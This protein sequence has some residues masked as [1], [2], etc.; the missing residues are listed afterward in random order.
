M[1]QPLVLLLSLGHLVV[2][3]AVQVVHDDEAGEDRHDGDV[4]DGRAVQAVAEAAGGLQLGLHPAAALHGGELPRLGTFVGKDEAI[5]VGGMLQLG[6]KLGE[7][8]ASCRR[9]HSRDAHLDG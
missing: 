3:R 2:L 5:G 7:K 4:G 1:F 8:E 6:C 9:G